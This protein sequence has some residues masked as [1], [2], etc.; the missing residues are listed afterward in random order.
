MSSPTCVSGKSSPGPNSPPC[1]HSARGSP[2]SAWVVRGWAAATPYG[3][4]DRILLPW[5]HWSLFF[6]PRVL[7]SGGGEYAVEG[8]TIVCVCLPLAPNQGDRSLVDSVV[9]SSRIRFDRSC[10]LWVALAACIVGLWMMNAIIK[11][12]KYYQEGGKKWRQ[13]NL[14]LSPMVWWI[15]RLLY[16]ISYPLFIYWIQRKISKEDSDFF[17]NIWMEFIISL[18][19]QW[20][21]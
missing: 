8:A 6:R 17:I 18:T 1:S 14:N 15:I 20:C 9:T 2:R 4:T 11:I 19:V 12:I 13:G 21:R 16:R 5:P 3:V 7:N 10:A